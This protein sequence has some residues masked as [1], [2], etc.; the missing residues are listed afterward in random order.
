M[1]FEARPRATIG[2]SSGL[3]TRRGLFSFFSFIPIV[4]A[5]E[6]RSREREGEGEGEGEFV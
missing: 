2:V 3:F 1:I 4:G 5:T 6:T